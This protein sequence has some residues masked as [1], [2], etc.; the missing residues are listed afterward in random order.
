MLGFLLALV[1]SACA[2]LSFIGLAPA[3]EHHQANHAHLDRG[4]CVAASQRRS[5]IADSSRVDDRARGRRWL[6]RTRKDCSHGDR[7]SP[8]VESPAPAAPVPPA[9]APT[10]TLANSPV[11]AEAPL[12]NEPAP[13]GEPPASGEPPGPGE[14]GPPSEPPPPEEPAPNEPEPPSEPP[15]EP[16]SPSEPPPEEEP[17]PPTETGGEPPTETGD[18]PTATAE[19]FAGQPADV[20]VTFPTAVTPSEAS[21]CVGLDSSGQP[22]GFGA[23]DPGPSP[24]TVRLQLVPEGEMPAQVRCP[25]EGGDEVLPVAAAASAPGGV[26]DD[27]IDP[28]FLSEVP[29]GRRSFWIQPWRAY[30]DTWPASRLL[31]AP[32][33]NFNVTAPEADGT[34]RLLHDSGFN[35]ARIEINWNALSYANPNEFNNEADIRTR[36]VALREHHL[37]PLILLNANSGAPGPAREVILTTLSSAPAGSRSVALSP[38]SAAEVVPGKTGFAGLT[39]GGDPDLLITSVDGAGIASLSRPLP[40]ALPSGDHRGATL[41]YAP[42]GPPTLSGGGVNPDFAV[43]LKGW[44]RYVSTVCREASEVFGPD[45]YD[46]EVWNELSFASEFLHEEKYYSPPRSDGSGSIAEALLDET[47]AYIRDPESGISPAVGVS[48]GF[49]SQTPF[50]SGRSVPVGT[51]A[52]SKHPYRG[53]QY[54]PRDAVVDSNQ[55]VDALGESDARGNRAPFTPRFTPEYASALPEYFLTATQTETLIR[56]VA[57]Q[58]TTIYGVPHGRSVGP[59][60][61]T[62]PQ[63]WMTEYNLNTNTLFPVDPE[64]PT[65]YIGHRFPAQAERLQAEIVLRSLVSMVGKGVARE[66]FYAAA[67]AEGYDLISEAF[68][69]ALDADPNGYPGDRL[70]GETMAALGQMLARF[71]GPGPDGPARQLEL[72]SIAQEGNH[73]EFAGDGTAA[74][75][76]LYDRDLLAVLPFQSAPRR[77]VVPVYV[78]T[79]NLT[80]V[81]DM[82]A[83]E[84]SPTRF[85]LPDENFRITLGN[86]PETAEPPAVSAYDPMRGEATPARFVSRQGDRAVFE[87]AATDYPRLLTIDYQ[88]E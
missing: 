27:P 50:P 20:L 19:D 32:G 42:F 88:G 31:A 23:V 8:H 57:P 54:F 61:G 10:T 68:I 79:P 67:H 48:D 52:L 35:L 70:G 18:T 39:F 56:D 51:T 13:P 65:D 22:Q 60:G 9:P 74:H 45:G 55:P 11:A 69:E 58:T 86:L 5:G 84:K 72:R 34:A 30:L 12:P 83:P 71:Q 24:S 4:R 21:A 82:N 81:S 66:Y 77:F 41:R 14:P 49:A 62:P 75:P 76:D 38:A 47:V 46:L 40:A 73:A 44:L 64:H 63:L 28:R 33:I 17:A 85:D 37:R 16:G 78:M 3:K 25:S 59:P 36:L 15:G 1:V 7:P 26:V 6:A 53:P 87:I 43:T 80:T 29:F 2:V